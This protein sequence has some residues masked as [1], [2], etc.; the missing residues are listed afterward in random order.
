MPLAITVIEGL[1][2]ISSTKDAVVME[3]TEAPATTAFTL[4]QPGKAALEAGEL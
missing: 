3:D 2:V 4:T 1:V